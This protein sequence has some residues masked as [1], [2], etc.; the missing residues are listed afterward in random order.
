MN[1]PII[2]SVLRGI[3]NILSGDEFS[4]RGLPSNF[5]Y[6]CGSTLFT[7]QAEFDDDYELTAYLT[8]AECAYCHTKLTAPTPL[9]KINL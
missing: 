5:C 1:I 9:D 3:A 7:I 2:P 4:W 8:N 6:E